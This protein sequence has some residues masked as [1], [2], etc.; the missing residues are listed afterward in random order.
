MSI[1]RLQPS[2]GRFDHA[3]LRLKRHVMRLHHG[4]PNDPEKTTRKSMP[5]VESHRRQKCYRVW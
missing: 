1:N 5:S 4:T 3:P 2:A